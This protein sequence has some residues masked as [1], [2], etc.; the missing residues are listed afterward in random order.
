[1]SVLMSATRSCSRALQEQVADATGAIR[2]TD[3]P[4]S[5]VQRLDLLD[6]RTLDRFRAQHGALADQALDAHHELLAAL[7]T[8][9]AA[10]EEAARQALEDRI[11][12]R[13]ILTVFVCLS[14]GASDV[15]GAKRRWDVDRAMRRSGL[16]ERD[17]LAIARLLAEAWAEVPS[18]PPALDAFSAEE[19]HDLLALV[20]EDV[21]LATLRESYGPPRAAFVTR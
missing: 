7:E 4:R 14:C 11:V 13:P 8:R 15:A 19:L 16:A 21:D 3:H 18:A 9:L 20:G 6:D 2:R 1:M 17:L 12:E 5:D 10:V